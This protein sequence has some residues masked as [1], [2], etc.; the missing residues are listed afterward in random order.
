MYRPRTGFT[1]KGESLM[2]SCSVKIGPSRN[3]RQSTRAPTRPAT[4]STR[5][6]AT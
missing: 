2:P 5:I 1:L 4:A 3:G 6:A